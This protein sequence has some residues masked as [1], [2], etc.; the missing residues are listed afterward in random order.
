MFSCDGMQIATTS[1][2]KRCD[3]PVFLPDLRLDSRT[4]ITCPD[5]ALWILP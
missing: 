3:L 2:T 1:S 5:D 4:A